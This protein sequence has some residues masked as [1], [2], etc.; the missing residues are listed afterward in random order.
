MN[1]PS[2]LIVVT[3]F[4]VILS[5]FT[6]GTFEN[7]IPL[8]KR[9]R[10][11][12]IGSQYLSELQKSRGLSQKDIDE[13]ESKLTEIGFQNIRVMAPTSAEWGHEATLRIDADYV[14]ERTNMD[15]KKEE[16][17]KTATFEETTVIMTND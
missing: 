4:I 15:M 6:V 9:I 3:I 10:F 7:S 13:I 16:N 8:F 12:N 2:N 5:V 1:F 17:V 14:F 11:D